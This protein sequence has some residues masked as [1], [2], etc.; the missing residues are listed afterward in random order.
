MYNRCSIQNIIKHVKV[1][2]NAEKYLV[3]DDLSCQQSVKDSSHYR[4]VTLLTQPTVS[5]SY[6]TSSHNMAWNDQHISV[7]H[8]TNLHVSA[9]LAVD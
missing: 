5:I 1:I 9:F 2:Y 7:C 6:H 4:T 8:P 3:H